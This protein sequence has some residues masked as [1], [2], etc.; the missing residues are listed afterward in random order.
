MGGKNGLSWHDACFDKFLAIRIFTFE[1]EAD[2]S[3]WNIFYPHFLIN[4]VAEITP[5]QLGE[6]G[7]HNLFLDVDCTLK[8]YRYQ[9]PTPDAWNW[10]QLM[11]AKGVNLCLLSNGVG[12]RIANFA[13]RVELPFVAKACKPLPRGCRRAMKE[14]N[15]KPEET[16]LVG[17][18]IFADVIAGRLCGL[19]TFKVAPISPEE[20]HWFTRIKRPFENVVLRSFKRRFPEGVWIE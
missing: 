5:E 6:L 11:R 17:D 12:S 18:Q 19:R 16:A 10:L 8:R 3:M 2:P 15:F 7:I 20:E 1:K 13:Q 4:S 14:F 9:E